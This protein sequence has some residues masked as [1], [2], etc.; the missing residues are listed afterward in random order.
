MKYYIADYR[1]YDGEHE[2]LESGVLS[3]RTFETAQKRAV[4]GRSLFTR[5]GWEEFCN[6]ESIHEI[7]KAD[8][9][10][11]QKYLTKIRDRR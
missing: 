11:L 10:V 4:K 8:F 2:Y 7:P 1:T 9:E 5:Y 6:F 3:A